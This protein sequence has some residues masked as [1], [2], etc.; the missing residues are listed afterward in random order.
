MGQWH[1]STL[2]FF[3]DFIENTNQ[4]LI[5]KYY[6]ILY[7]SKP[8]TESEY[9]LEFMELSEDEKHTIVQMTTKYSN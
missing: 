3:Q 7:E 2:A 1:M 4:D 5:L 8:A 9:F 6:D